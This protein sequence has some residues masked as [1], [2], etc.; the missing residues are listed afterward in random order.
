MYEYLE[1]TWDY[2]NCRKLLAV[3]FSIVKY[4]RLY[5]PDSSVCLLCTEKNKETKINREHRWVLNSKNRRLFPSISQS[6][7][8]KNRYPLFL[9]E[10]RRK[11]KITWSLKCGLLS[12]NK[13][14]YLWHFCFLKAVYWQ[15][16][17]FRIMVT[18]FHKNCGNVK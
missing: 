13:K 15:G 10:S 1:Y 3:N 8:A 12:S 16:N 9:S 2:T 6:V 7:C 18:Q 11:T 5:N 17:F 14:R 4:T